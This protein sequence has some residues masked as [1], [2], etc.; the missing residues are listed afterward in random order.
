MFLKRSRIKNTGHLEHPFPGSGLFSIGKVYR[1]IAA[2]L[3][4]DQ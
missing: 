1:T 3:F 4:Q 2:G